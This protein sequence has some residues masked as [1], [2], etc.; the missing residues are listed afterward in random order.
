MLMSLTNA[1]QDQITKDQITEERIVQMVKIAMAKEASTQEIVASLK[2]HID[3]AIER[4]FDKYTKS[5][6]PVEP[7]TKYHTSLYPTHPIPI[8]KPPNTTTIRGQLVPPLN[9]NP[10]CTPSLVKPFQYEPLST[11]STISFDKVIERQTVHDHTFTNMVNE[12]TVSWIIKKFSNLIQINDELNYENI[13]E[14][15]EEIQNNVI[16]HNLETQ[17]N[18]WCGDDDKVEQLIRKCWLKKNPYS[19]KH[20]AIPEMVDFQLQP[21]P[22][23]DF[24][25]V[26]Y[27]DFGPVTYPDSITENSSENKTIQW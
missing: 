3:N 11:F 9:Y 14:I 10:S 21:M 7:Q 17:Y 2:T 22:D 26:P 16:T 20:I 12:C 18:N 24:G 25:P 19:D 5:L 8:G 1:F 27:P 4:A 23:P 13:V 6:D 15:K